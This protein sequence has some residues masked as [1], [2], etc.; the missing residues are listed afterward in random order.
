MVRADRVSASVAR[1]PVD[2]RSGGRVRERRAG[3]AA[4]GPGRRSR[5]HRARG[6]NAPG[7]CGGR[8]APA[9]PALL[10]RC[11]ARRPDPA[12]PAAPG[13][14]SPGARRSP[15]ARALPISRG[16]R[17]AAPPASDR[18]FAA[19]RPRADRPSVQHRG[20]GRLRRD[21]SRR[22]GDADGAWRPD[23]DSRLDGRRAG[24]RGGGPPARARAP[25]R[26]AR[27]AISRVRRRREDLARAPCRR[28]PRR[29]VRDRD[30]SGRRRDRAR[31]RA[32]DLRLRGGR[33]RPDRGGPDLSVQRLDVSPLALQRALMMKPPMWRRAAPLLIVAV[34]GPVSAQSTAVVPYPRDYTSRLVKYAVRSEEHTSELQSL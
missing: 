7:A 8:T 2:L 22:G 30:G 20:D 21:A 18:L 32:E 27:R 25:V 1:S 5:P 3:V 33:R 4:H 26:R 9:P 31:G 11:R 12:R 29:G 15:G 14:D 16:P 34:V 10:R 13:P 23:D 28:A 6:S 19:R 24:A 17:T